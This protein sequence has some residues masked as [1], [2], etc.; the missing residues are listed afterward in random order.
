MPMRKVYGGPVRQS[1]R[2]ESPARVKK[3]RRRIYSLRRFY[4]LQKGLS[5][6]LSYK[7]KGLRSN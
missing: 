3:E 2:I 5:K 6:G 7:R 1:G 4:G